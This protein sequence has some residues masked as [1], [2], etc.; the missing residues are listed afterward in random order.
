MTTSERAPAPTRRRGRWILVVALLL[1]AA[2]VVALTT[3]GSV[4]RLIAGVAIVLVPGAA[5]VTILRLRP[6][7]R[8]EAIVLALGLGVAA[9][10]VGG[11]LIDLAA[12]LSPAGWGG[13]IVLLVGV[14]LLTARS[15]A[16]ASAARSGKGRA[17]QARSATHGLCS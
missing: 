7:D 12:T 1:A 10:I 4:L 13:F 3:D 9:L 8:A 2:L 6:R 16:A 14:A 17:C 5:L 11:L 15:R